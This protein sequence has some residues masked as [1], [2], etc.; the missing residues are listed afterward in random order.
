MERTSRYRFPKSCFYAND[1]S[2]NSQNERGVYDAGTD[3]RTEDRR[4]FYVEPEMTLYA[5]E[6]PIPV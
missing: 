4:D 6:Q 3:N 1:E 2:I 5:Q